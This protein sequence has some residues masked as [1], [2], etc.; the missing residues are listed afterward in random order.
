M[1]FNK[2]RL[3]AEAKEWLSSLSLNTFKATFGGAAW[4]PV[5]AYYAKDC[6]AYFLNGGSNFHLADIEAKQQY[7]SLVYQSSV[8]PITGIV[9]SRLREDGRR[10]A[11]WDIERIVM[12]AALEDD[13]SVWYLLFRAL[14]DSVRNIPK[15]QDH[16]VAFEGSLA[17]LPVVS[18]GIY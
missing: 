13:D 7:Y 2:L 3:S 6:D 16:L 10:V 5:F 4:V 17:Q 15:E 8:I 11:T 18:G 12:P 9:A 1:L 14:V